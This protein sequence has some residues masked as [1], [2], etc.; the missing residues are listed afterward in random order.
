M[1]HEK[2]LTPFSF[3]DCF[4]FSGV[5]SDPDSAVSRHLARQRKL[6][7]QAG[8]EEDFWRTCSTISALPCKGRLEWSSF[9][10]T[11]NCASGR[12]N[13]LAMPWRASPV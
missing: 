1:A 9:C 8:P 13:T 2:R 6:L 11:R 12:R 4:D 10:R 7:S 3:P 5:Q